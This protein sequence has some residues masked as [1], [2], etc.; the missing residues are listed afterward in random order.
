VGKLENEY[1]RGL[2]KR[3]ET[4]FPGC[5]VLKNDE[6]LRQGIPDMIILFGSR[7]AIVEVKRSIDASWR[8]NQE[9]Y[10]EFVSNM[11]GIAFFICPENEREVLDE[12]QRAFESER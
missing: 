10:L 1:K 12:I 2:K 5:L 11:G 8:P 3:I 9:Y 6:Q 7:Y 4:R